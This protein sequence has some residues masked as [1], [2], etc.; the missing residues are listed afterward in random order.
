MFL[1]L[2]ATQP[3]EACRKRS[4]VERIPVKVAPGTCTTVYISY[5]C[6]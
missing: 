2:R 3:A 1:P 5:S 4:G 6:A